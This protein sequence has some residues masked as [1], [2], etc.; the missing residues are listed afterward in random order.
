MQKHFQCRIKSTVLPVYS[1]YK[2]I[3]SKK[4]VWLHTLLKFLLTV[5]LLRVSTGYKYHQLVLS[6]HIY[7]ICVVIRSYCFEFKH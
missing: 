4:F 2:E 6:H 1:L 7:L 5:A 3:T